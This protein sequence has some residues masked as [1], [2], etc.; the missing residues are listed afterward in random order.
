MRSPGR[1]RPLA[2][3]LAPVPPEDDAEAAA[4]RAHYVGS[5]EHKRG[6]SSAGNPRL[7]A[8]ATPC[9]PEFKDP[10]ALTSWL[11]QAIRQ[12]MTGGYWEQGL[13]RYAWWRDGDSCYEARLVNAGLGEY[14]G[15]P[16]A[17][18]EWPAEL[19]R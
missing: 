19:A 1:R 3:K 10:D 12:G 11:R 8:D 6:L 17:A 13:P 2:R 15:W 18:D 16:L 7:R 5:A 4:R 14:K 9:P